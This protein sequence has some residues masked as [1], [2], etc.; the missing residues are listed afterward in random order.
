MHVAT[1]RLGRRQRG[2]PSQ[3]VVWKTPPDYVLQFGSAPIEV[4]VQQPAVSK[5][6]RACVWGGGEVE[7]WY[8]LIDVLLCF[9]VRQ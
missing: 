6:Q 9:F 3:A 2:L 1:F 4:N 7:P 5:I 8:F